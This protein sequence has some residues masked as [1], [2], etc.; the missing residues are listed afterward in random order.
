ME[1]QEDAIAVFVYIKK[2]KH[3]IY[4]TT[5]NYVSLSYILCSPRSSRAAGMVL[6]TCDVRL[7]W[8]NRASATVVTRLVC[9]FYINEL[10][11]VLIIFLCF[12]FQGTFYDGDNFINHRP[13]LDISTLP[14]LHE[15]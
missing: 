8:G 10:F 6:Q 11:L 13:P 5:I 15:F 7:F 14:F 3:L 9:A 4:I 12:N 2:L 1:R